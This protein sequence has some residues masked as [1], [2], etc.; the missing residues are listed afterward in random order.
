MQDT[1][2][3][4]LAAATAAFHEAG[5]TVARLLPEVVKGYHAKKATLHRLIEQLGTPEES[6]DRQTISA[7]FLSHELECADDEVTALQ[8]SEDTFRKV[9]N[10]DY[11]EHIASTVEEI[12]SGSQRAYNFSAA[13][14][15][16]N[17]QAYDNIP[18]KDLQFL[19]E[20]DLI[21]YAKKILDL[22]TLSEGSIV[23]GRACQT[24]I[25]GYGTIF[26][27]SDEDGEYYW[28]D[29]SMRSGYIWDLQAWVDRIPLAEAFRIL[30]DHFAGDIPS[31]KRTA[32]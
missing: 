29:E 14:E 9:V 13:V 4:E 7:G 1:N 12:A 2:I 22:E 17:K 15:T 31:S 10:L 18:G 5:R 11:I 3:R 32:A 24:F 16:D 25:H 19:R 30:Q 21:A 26:I 28:Q 20:Q 27:T 23:N 8:K 6:F